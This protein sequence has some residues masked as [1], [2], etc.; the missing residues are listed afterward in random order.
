M[1]SVIN[2]ML[3]NI[4][5]KF[6]L[7][8]LSDYIKMS[9]YHFVRKFKETTG[10]SPIQYFNRLKIQ[11]ACELLDTTSLDINEISLILSFNT[12]YYFSE[13]FKKIVGYSPSK[14]R[15]FGSNGK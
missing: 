5:T 14:Y 12:P 1:E 8:Q 15:R 3:Q 11:K 9:K 7:E 10:Y 2:Y 4:D 13:V 6:S